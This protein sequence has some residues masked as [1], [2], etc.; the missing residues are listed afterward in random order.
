MKDDRDLV[1]GWVIVVFA[2]LLLATTITLSGR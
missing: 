1:V 2:L